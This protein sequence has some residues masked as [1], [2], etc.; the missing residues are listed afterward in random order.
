MYENM[1]MACLRTYTGIHICVQN[2]P[3]FI[4]CLFQEK[5]FF[6]LLCVLAPVNTCSYMYR[7]MC[8]GN[9]ACVCAYMLRPDVHVGHYLLC[10]LSALS[11]EVQSLIGFVRLA[12]SVPSLP[13]EAVKALAWHL[14]GSLGS[15]L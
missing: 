1:Y 7:H 11:I 9:P 4:A 14:L 5:P 12:P 13:S 2:S 3:E 10:L 15:E 6:F 8:V